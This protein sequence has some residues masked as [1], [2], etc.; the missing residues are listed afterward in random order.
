MA[1]GVSL[2]QGYSANGSQN[3]SESWSATDATSARAWSEQQATVAFERQRQLMQEQMA[4]NSAEA[5]LARQFN[6]D[7][8][9]KARNFSS[10]EAKISRDWQA[11]MANSL[12]TRS[13]KNMKEAGINPILAA[14]MGLSGAGV[15][16]GASASTMAASGSGASASMGSAP[17][18]QN[19]MDSQ[20]G[21]SAKGNSWGSSENGLA[22]ALEAM[23]A[24][25]S[26]A[27]GAVQS[28]QAIN[29]IGGYMGKTFTNGLD[30]MIK[31]ITNG[32]ESLSS[33]S[34]TAQGRSNGFFEGST[35]HANKESRIK[36]KIF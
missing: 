12:Y 6:A 36:D 17:L 33:I 10:T 8:A 34:G 18:A 20:S 2:G 5:A 28:G 26:A 27:L 25:I 11:D 22:T 30:G 23:G 21:S 31:D 15:G 4:F 29:I 14:N 35:K 24:M 7:E 16:S 1:I 3:S 9:L 32:K 19:F 13:A